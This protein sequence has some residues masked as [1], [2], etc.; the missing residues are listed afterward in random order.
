MK[1]QPTHGAYKTSL[2][3]R[4]VAMKT[5]CVNPNRPEWPRYGGRGIAF[6]AEWAKFEPFRDWAL[7]N[8]Y[9][10]SLTLERKDNNGGYSP[11]NCC[12][13][14]VAEQNRNRDLG[15]RL[16]D[17]RLM[18]DVAAAHGVT[19]SAVRNRVY[20]GWD[21]LVAVTT[22]L[23]FVSPLRGHTRSKPKAG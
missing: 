7:A 18:M 15:R 17:G 5:R 2:Y 20:H 14:T 12:W 21:D 13:A 6:C 9:E 3:R 8:G 10:A 4:W 16:P 22:P 19:M 23:K 11:E 1:F